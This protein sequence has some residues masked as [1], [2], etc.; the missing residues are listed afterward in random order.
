VLSWRASNFNNPVSGNNEWGD[1]S[2]L[3]QK[4]KF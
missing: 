1:A 3:P 4:I 2:S